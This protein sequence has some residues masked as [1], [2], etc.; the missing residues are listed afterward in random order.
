MIKI[1]KHLK[2]YWVSV[3]LVIGLLFL[4]ANCDLALPEYTSRIVN[5]GIQQGG[6]DTN[7][8]NVIRSS[9]L[10]HSFLFMDETDAT[11]VKKQ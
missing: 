3:L 5:V 11:W 6:I 10:E 7:T 1:L 9:S 8:P 2:K 4:Q